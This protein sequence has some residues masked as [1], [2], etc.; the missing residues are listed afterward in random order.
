MGSET[1]NSPQL[2]ISSIVAKMRQRETYAHSVADSIELVQTHIS[3]IFLTGEYA[4]K[5]KKRVNLGFLDFSTLDK[6]QHFLQEE[7]RLNREIAPDLYLEVLPISQQ[8]DKL[9]LGEDRAV[10]EYTLKMHQFP[11][12]NLFI[13]LFNQDRLS[14]NKMRELGKIV[15]QFH[16]KAPS[17]EYIRSF[18]KPANI[19]L[20]FDQNYQQTEKYIG[21]VQ[22][23][24]QFDE[25]KAF[26]DKFFSDRQELFQARIDA[27]K[28]KECHGD[29]HLKN[30]CWWHNKIQL[31]D[32]IEFNEAFR[33]V[34]VMYDVA[35]T[36]MDL[37]IRQR[38]DFAN[39]FLNNYLEYTGDW[40]GLPILPLYLSRQAYVRAKTNS[41]LLDDAE[42]SEPEKQQARATAAD[43]YHQA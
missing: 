14:I 19:K 37:E 39:A 12:E 10:V 33:F 7:I 15:A 26:T 41:F 31:F 40:S 43:Y 8:E 32:R 20:A 3:Y 25:T 13:N 2:D 27:H 42:I 6:R 9:F 28:I 34:D 21:T 29:L 35:F 22:T 5:I 16:Q 17:N 18:G 4:Y 1:S 36:V 30:I 23:Q 24:T 11:Q 38:R